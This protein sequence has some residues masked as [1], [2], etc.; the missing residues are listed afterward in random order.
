MELQLR[1]WILAENIKRISRTNKKTFK[2]LNY[3]VYNVFM[4]ILVCIKLKE[5]EEET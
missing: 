2:L 5:N 4:P 3:Y 1:T